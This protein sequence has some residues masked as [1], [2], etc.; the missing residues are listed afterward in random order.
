MILLNADVSL[1]F[2]HLFTQ[3]TSCQQYQF[4]G[5]VIISRSTHLC[6]VLNLEQIDIDLRHSQ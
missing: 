2:M 4:K 1:D 6:A 3:K 5:E